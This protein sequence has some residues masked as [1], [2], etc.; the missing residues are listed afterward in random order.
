M[1][2]N[3][4]DFKNDKILSYPGSDNTI[5]CITFK[6]IPYIIQL[7]TINYN[8]Y[9][10]NNSIFLS[11]N[12]GIN[13]PLLYPMQNK[14]NNNEP[15]HYPTQ[16]IDNSFYNQTQDNNNF[17]YN[18][19]K[20]INNIALLNQIINN[21][22]FSL[23]TPNINKDLFNFQTQNKDVYRPLTQ[24]IN[25]NECN[26]L[27]QN[28]NINIYSPS[29]QVNG[30][31]NFPNKDIKRFSHN[32][33]TQYDYK[34]F[35]KPIQNFNKDFHRPTQ[36]NDKNF[37]RLTQDS[38]KDFN[39]TTQNSNNDC[40]KK[41][42]QDSNKDFYRTTQD[43]NND[44]YRK[45]IQDSNKDF[46]RTIQDNN[47]KFY[48]K[49]IQDKDLYIQDNDNDFYRQVQNINKGS[50]RPR[51]DIKNE[52]YIQENDFK[53]NIFNEIYIKPN[54]RN[55]Y[56][57]DAKPNISMYNNK[58]DNYFMPNVKSRLKFKKYMTK[59]PLKNRN[60]K[61]DKSTGIVIR[62]YIS[63]FYGTKPFK[64]EYCGYSF[65]R[66]HDLIRHTRLHTGVKPYKCD[67]CQ[68]SFYRSDAL[69]RHL[70]VNP[71]CSL[72]LKTKLKYYK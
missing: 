26:T 37:Y 72:N 23:P 50:Y 6:P 9:N 61:I 18:N 33:P 65:K 58:K 45:P 57:Q 39:I 21:S 16:N 38:N 68:K 53:G 31:Y 43:N 7:P 13:K 60:V 28:I 46:Y 14:A 15:L 66:K 25:E 20:V 5:N 47:N 29:T 3:K 8:N 24:N 12:Y 1:D 49:P 10:S 55:S 48:R 19:T 69:R 40:Y 2:I 70:R 59:E 11:E 36:D 27:T 67:F 17:L 56:H 71:D 41:P 34:N 44:F 4:N 51:Q 35:S 30:L 32:I 52:V 22:L 63:E 54:I 62:S 42:I 64:C